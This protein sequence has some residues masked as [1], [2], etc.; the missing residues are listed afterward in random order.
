VVGLEQ[1]TITTQEIFRFEKSGVDELGT[2]IGEFRS[3]GIRPKAI[4][5]FQG[6]GIHLPAATFESLESDA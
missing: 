6:A 1:S 4:S 2:V 5:R 3:T